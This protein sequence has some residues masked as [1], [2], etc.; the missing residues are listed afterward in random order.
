MD[1]GLPTELAVCLA[2]LWETAE[3]IYVVDFKQLFYLKRIV[4][5]AVVPYCD[6]CRKHM[7]EFVTRPD[8]K[9]Q[10][11]H[12]FQRVPR[13]I[14]L[15]LLLILFFQT[16]N[17]FD[18]DFR[19][20]DEFKMEM[21]MRITEMKEALFDICDN[22]ML[23]SEKERQRMIS[24]NWTS[25]QLIE[26][27]N[28]VTNFIQLELDRCVDTMQVVNDYY[29]CLVTKMPSDLLLPKIIIVKLTETNHEEIVAR[30]DEEIME[31]MRR[32]DAEF[33]DSRIE[34]MLN[35][36]LENSVNFVTTTL[37]QAKGVMEK[38]KELFKPKKGGKEKTPR[39]QPT[40]K[41]APGNV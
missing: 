32:F 36:L 8:N 40:K 4:I 9:Q 11:V 20:D 6:F 1:L 39:K 35:V 14:L 31:G 5:D 33:D 19:S 7:Y 15:D 30:L 34:T 29:T 18:N 17:E 12:D 13:C 22:I 27:Y 2:T 41:D 21:H 10:Y 16:Y 25:R 26:M 24:E 23:D 37:N 3:K 28:I 38:V